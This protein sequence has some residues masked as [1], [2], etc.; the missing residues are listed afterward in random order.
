MDGNFSPAAIFSVVL[1]TVV[2]SSSTAFL[3]PCDLLYDK[4]VQAFSNGDYTNVVRYMEGALS[5]FTEVRHTKVRCRLRCQ[6]QHPFDETFSDLRFTDVLLRRAACMNTCIEE[7]LGT[8]SV[9]K[10]SE[11]VV[12]D[13]HRRIPYNYLQLAYQKVSEGG[14]AE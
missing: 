7:K 8:Q 12:Q 5:S 1:L 14:V 9:H 6:D 2:L 3:E 11:D 10:I 13:F 4:A